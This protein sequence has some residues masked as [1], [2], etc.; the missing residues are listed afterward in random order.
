MCIRDTTLKKNDW[1]TYPE[2]APH[3]PLSG[4]IHHIGCKSVVVPASGRRDGAIALSDLA[5]VVHMDKVT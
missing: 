3:C 2:V 4:P 1:K 5:R